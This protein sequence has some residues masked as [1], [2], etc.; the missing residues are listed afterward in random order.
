MSSAISWRY[1]SIWIERSEADT[2][3]ARRVVERLPEVPVQWFE[4]GASIEP[5]TLAEGKRQLVVQRHRGTFLQHCPAGTTGMVCCNYL[6]VNFASNCPFD[7]SYCFLQDYVANNPATKLFSNVEEGLAELA[8]ALDRHPERQFRVG[9][10]ELA[11]SLALDPL[12][13]LTRELVPFFAARDNAVLELK[14]KSDRIENLLDLDSRGRV[15]I[16]WSVNAPQIIDREEHGVASLEQ[17]IAAAVRLQAAGYRVGFHFDPL[18]AH[19]GWEAGYQSVVEQIFARVDPRQ[20]AWVS[21]GSLRLT[22][23]LKTAI[24]ARHERG[25]ILSGELVPCAD[26]KERAW[27]GLRVKMYRRML[28][29]LRAVDPEM[30]LYIC[31]EPAGVWEKVMGEAPAD[32]DLGR[33]LTLDFGQPKSPTLE[34][35]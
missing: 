7:C 17:R 22:P 20:V 19:D 18:V 23:R 10:G 8:T 35:A 4:T 13:D 16:S 2:A 1:D 12:C 31:M 9:T 32:R 26:G 28:A 3:L 29:W 5:A 34:P 6:V 25:Q 30:Q 24:R 33:R 11:D 21:L 15:V 14:T 27:R